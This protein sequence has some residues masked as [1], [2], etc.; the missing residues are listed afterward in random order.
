[1]IN[2]LPLCCSLTEAKYIKNRWQK[3]IEL[4]KKDLNDPDNHDGMITH[5][6]PSQVGL[7]KI[8][9]NK[10]SGGDG[11]PVQL[12]QILKDDAFKGLHSICQKIW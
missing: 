6:E 12:Y 10:A 9:T 11:I 2:S 3:Y 1:M 5:V 7:R 4:Y 8:I